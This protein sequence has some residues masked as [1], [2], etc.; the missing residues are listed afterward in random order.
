MLEKLREEVCEMNLEL[1]RSRLVTMF[2]GNVSGRDPETGYVAI[3]PSGMNYRNMRPEDMVIVDMNGDVVEGKHKPSVDTLTH[4][5]IYK[6][7]PDVNGITHTH[8]N[9]A[10]SFAALGQSIPVYLTAMADDFGGPVPCTDY[11]PVGSEAIGKEILRVIGNSPAVLV[12][13]HG[14]F[15]I[16]KSPSEALKI[17]VML[18]DIAKTVHLALLRGKPQEIPP[19]EVQRAYEWHQKFYG[20]K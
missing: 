1:S 11:A 4:L 18:E 8:S 13:N 16:G 5:Y 9:Y 14:V 7:R 19:E 20:Q 3:K 12:K 15:T 17:A 2:S 6:N 10:T